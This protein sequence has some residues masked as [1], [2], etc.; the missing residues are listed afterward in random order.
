V[1]LAAVVLVAAGFLQSLAPPSATAAPKTPRALV[2]SGHDLATTVRVLLSTTPAIPGFNRF[3]LRVVD[4]DTHQPITG[5]AVTLTFLLPSDPNL[6]PSTLNLSPQKNG[7][8][9]A[10]AA[11][12]SVQGTWTVTAL[13]QRASQSAEVSLPLTTLTAPVKIDQV[14]SP[15]LP[16]IYNIHVTAAVTMQVYL[17]PGHAGLNEFHVTMIGAGDQEIPTSTVTVN[18]GRTSAPLAA[19]T[20]HRLDNIGHFV[21]LLLDAPAGNYHFSIDATS[22]QGPFHADITIPVS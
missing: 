7:E 3:T 21:F 5:A 6:G 15:G 11:N 16:T 22:N 1:G 12:L 2:V 20:A 13:I 19:L 9:V 4:F 17:D 14:R 18:A 8:Y 10:D